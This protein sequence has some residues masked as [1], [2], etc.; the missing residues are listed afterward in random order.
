MTAQKP[1]EVRPTACKTCGSTDGKALWYAHDMYL[2]ANLSEAHRGWHV[3]QEDCNDGFPCHPC[4]TC[5]APKPALCPTC[6]GEK[7]TPRYRKMGKYA[8]ASLSAWHKRDEKPPHQNVSCHG[9]SC[10]CCADPF[11]SQPQAKP[12]EQ[13]TMTTQP[14]RCGG[15]P[16][17]PNW[18]RLARNPRIWAT[19]ATPCPGCADCKPQEKEARKDD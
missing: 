2:Q 5:S 3:Q 14:E 8:W 11:H 18:R 19:N 12:A 13:K 10:R 9:T 17:K 15:T 7:D 6:G 1:D 4:P 16:G